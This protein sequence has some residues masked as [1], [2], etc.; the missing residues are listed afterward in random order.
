[1][2]DALSP[3]KEAVVRA[4]VERGLL[5]EDSLLAGFIDI[6]G[7]E[8]TVASLKADFGANFTHTFAAKANCLQSVLSLLRARGMGCEVASPGEL[9]QAINAGFPPEMIVFDSPAK[10]MAELRFALERGIAINIDNFQEYDRVLAIVGAGQPRSVLGFRLNPQ[11]GVGTIAA[12]STATRTS[13][14][15]VALDDNRDA[16]LQAYARHPW[17]TCVHTHVGSQGCPFELIVHGVGKAVAFAE[18]VNKAAGHNQVTT[19]DIGGGLPVNFESDQVRPTFAEY[20]AVLREGIPQLFSGG[21]RIVT[22]FGRSILAK[23][24]FMCAR[25]EYTKTTGGRRIAITHAGAQTATRTVFMPDMW[26][27]RVSAVDHSGTGKFGDRVEQ[28]VAGPCCFAGDIIARGR[29]LPSLD[30]GDYVVIHDTGAYYFSTPFQYNSLPRIAVHG[31]RI[32]DGGAVTFELFREQESPEQILEATR[33]P[34][35]ARSG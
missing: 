25:V 20:A 21:Y 28:D 27:V 29:H 30:A 12:M 11:V 7:V 23:N 6:A 5:S 2:D 1:M 17:L 9:H 33:A 3:R 19:L 15:G 18:E 8:R 4:A 26:A 13:K 14:F 10:T 32:D 31:F 34:N 24:G 35:K 16:L 22:E